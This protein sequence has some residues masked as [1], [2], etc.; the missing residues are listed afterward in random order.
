[1]VYTGFAGELRVSYWLF[2][3]KLGPGSSEL[4]GESIKKVL[5]SKRTLKESYHRK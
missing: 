1:M 4:V 5:E 2:R 3:H